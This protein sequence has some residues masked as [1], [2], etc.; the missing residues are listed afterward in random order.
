MNKKLL[1]VLMGLIFAAGSTF[2]ATTGTLTVQGTVP[3]VLDIT[4]TA[5]AAASTL[6]LTVDGSDIIV[7]SV[8]ERSN[9]KAGY[10]VTLESANGIASSLSSGR[11]KSTDVTN[12]DYLDYSLKYGLTSITFT[13]GI[14]TITD[15]ATK[16]TGIGAQKN[17][18]ITYYG[19]SGVLLYKDTYRDNLTLTIIAK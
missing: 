16:T 10:S 2:A 6:D 15:S 19:A 8:V 11:F 5:A 7:A 4:V 1:L 9:K 14:A 3:A 18:S 17:L 12:T 13:N